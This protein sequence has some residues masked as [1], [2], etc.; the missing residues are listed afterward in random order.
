MNIG[1][2][3]TLEWRGREL[4]KYNFSSTS[5]VSYTYNA[6]GIRTSKAY[7]SGTSVTNHKYT[8]NGT[9]IVKEIPGLQ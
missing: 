6:D 2:N 4:K 7:A 3:V 5:N 9:Q 1:N 8:L